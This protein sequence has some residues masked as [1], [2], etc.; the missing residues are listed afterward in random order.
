[1]EPKFQSS[2]IPKKPLSDSSRVLA[3]VSKNTNIFS[4]IATI[5]FLITLFVSGGL[6]VYEK[7]IQKQ[8]G[9][10][11]KELDEA[12]VAFE[13]DKINELIDASVRLNSIKGMLEKHFAVSELLFLMQNLTMK[14]IQFG[15]FKLDN[16]SGQPILTMDG[17]ALSYNAVAK[18]SEVFLASGFIRNVIF[19]DFSLND[20]GLV[21]FRFTGAVVPRL[22]SYKEAVDALTQGNT[23]P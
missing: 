8:I 20:S 3:P 16:K 4:V 7:I 5:I 1:M 12:R 6:F 11:K 10:V 19:S 22:I 2:F 9:D 13:T 18:Q 14:T 17:E 15:N 23:Q 21:R